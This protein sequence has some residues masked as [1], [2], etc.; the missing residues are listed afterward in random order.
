MLRKRSEQWESSANTNGSP[1]IVGKSAKSEAA[2]TDD[3]SREVYGIL[4]MPIDVL[5]REAAVEK[6]TAAAR[7]SRSVLLSTP[8]LNFLRLSQ[9]DAQF[10]ETLLR[11]DLCVA[12]GMPIVWLARMLGVPIRQRVSG[13]DLF[14]ALK[15]NV[16]PSRPI[17]VFLFG[18][19][20]G[21][22]ETVSGRLN[23]RP[24]GM[25]CVGWLSPGFGS[26]GE[27]STDDILETIN[28]S[29]ADLLA[30][31]LG[32]KKA[33]SW[34][35][36]NH[37]RLRVPI[38]G[39]FGATINYQAGL[40]LRAPAIL[41]QLGLEWLWRIKEEP[42]LWQRYS[43]D[44]VFLLRLLLIRGIPIALQ[45]LKNY[46]RGRQK[47]EEMSLE[48]RRRDE[49]IVIALV[50]HATA[51]QVKQAV[52]CFRSALKEKRS[53]IIDVSRTLSIDPRFFGLLLMLRK[54][55]NKDGGFLQFVGRS[56]R[57]ERIFRI[58]G[59][60]FMLKSEG[61]NAAEVGQ[62]TLEG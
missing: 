20:E 12:D 23:A 32:A 60:E 26:V 19:A 10:R 16:S 54:Q 57:T 53:I 3:L 21:V 52:I 42:Y 50:G 11:S 1:S 58:N 25:S 18:G 48:Q 56:N 47:N 6:I 14:E 37:D 5:D 59:F 28:Q 51:V 15:S 13:S 7:E 45:R 4:G 30:V 40:V 34:L 62:A 61:P 36:K 41:Q 27:I 22:A 35:L 55:L 17:R 8:N 49:S 2:G 9:R 46:A 33:Q 38:Q 24:T 43:F 31:F 29:N 44:G 39:Q